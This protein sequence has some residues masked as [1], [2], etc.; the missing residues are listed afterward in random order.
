[1]GYE[2]AGA[3]VQTRRSFLLRMSS[4]VHLYTREHATLKKISENALSAF[5]LLEL[6]WM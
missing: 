6:R 5:P 1:M 4:R 2:L 3:I